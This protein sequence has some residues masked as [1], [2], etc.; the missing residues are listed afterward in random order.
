MRSICERTSVQAH[1]YS[2]HRSCTSRGI[3]LILFA[4]FWIGFRPIRSRPT[5]VNM[6]ETLQREKVTS[7][8]KRDATAPVRRS[9]RGYS[10]TNTATPIAGYSAAFICTLVRRTGHRHVGKPPAVT[11]CRRVNHAD[12]YSRCVALLA[13]AIQIDRLLFAKP[14]RCPKTSPRTRPRTRPRTPLPALPVPTPVRNP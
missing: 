2:R 9:Y 13:P 6:T 3:A 8:P 11:D 14:S 1:R 4:G 12:F 7:L 5:E 10:R